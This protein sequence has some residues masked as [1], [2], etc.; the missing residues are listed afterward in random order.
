[1]KR[2]EFLASLLGIPLISKLIPEEKVIGNVLP[3]VNKKISLLNTSEL[4]KYQVCLNRDLKFDTV[5]YTF[6]N[7][8]VYYDGQIPW[9]IDGDGNN[10]A[11]VEGFKLRKNKI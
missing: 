4:L 5:K 8:S 1:M 10:V 6:P 11:I 3:D 2:N 7:G 9:K